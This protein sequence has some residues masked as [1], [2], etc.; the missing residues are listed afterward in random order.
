ML[1]NT[2]IIED[3]ARTFAKDIWYVNRKDFVK[4]ALDALSA[5]REMRRTFI[6]SGDM[7]WRNNANNIMN[8]HKTT[9]KDFLQYIKRKKLF[10][11]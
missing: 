6:E 3:G 11:L 5:I 10:E 7:E 1:T 9:P 2:E 4:W 8:L